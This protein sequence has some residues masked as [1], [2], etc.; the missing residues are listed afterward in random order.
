MTVVLI[1]GKMSG[2]KREFVDA[3]ERRVLPLLK[4]RTNF[5][6]ALL[7]FEQD[8]PS[9]GTAMTLWG[10]SKGNGNWLEGQVKRIFDGG[11]RVHKFDIHDADR[12]SVLASK[13]LSPTAKEEMCAD[14]KVE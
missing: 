9:R 1:E 5:V 4:K 7:L 12:F 13:M 3:W 2:E 11:L 8:E 6:D 14:L 10:N